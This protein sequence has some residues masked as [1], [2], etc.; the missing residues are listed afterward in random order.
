[1]KRKWIALAVALCLCL[2]FSACSKRPAEGKK[3]K[4]S[5]VTSLFPQYDFARQV[6]GEFADI[7]L[8]LAPGAE[9][10]TYDPTYKDIESIAN[11]DIF[12]YTGENME[13]WAQTVLQS[14]GE[15]DSLTVLDL[16]EGIAMLKEEDGHDH[17]HE[18]DPH[19]WLNL[20]NAVTMIEKVTGALCEKSPENA[21][22]F[23]ANAEALKAEILEIDQAFLQTV[24]AAGEKTVVFGGRF[25]YRYFTERY[26]LHYKT[27][28]DS[29]STDVEPSA[30]TVADVTEY[31]K[32]NGIRYIYHEELADPKVASSIAEATGA[33][34]LEFSTGH[35]LSKS[36]FESGTTFADIMRRNLLNLKKGLES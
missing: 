31:M 21:D 33:E 1:M 15:K 28:Y 24:Q 11:A 6:A 29:C 23:N 14:V 4:L 26:G 34:L 3:E 18:S 9:A 27:V 20:E 19:I 10:H 13:P 30:K 32:Q 5:I 12:L 36:E 25:A 22:I 8:L 2:G 17:A 35:N 16:S 7:S